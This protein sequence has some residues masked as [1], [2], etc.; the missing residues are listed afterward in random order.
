MIGA[1]R[2]LKDLTGLRAHLED[3]L[4]ARCGERPDLETSLQEDYRKAF[5]RERTAGTYETWREERLTQ[6]AVAWILGC[7]F[8]RFLEDNA[9]VDPPRLSG[10]GDRRRRALDEHNLYFRAHPTDTDRE[11]L[12]H[13][14]RAVAA[15]PVAGQLFDETHNPLWSTDPEILS[16]DAA[17]R[18]LAL[19]QRI[20]PDSGALTH[21]FTDPAWDTRFLGDLY[22]NLSESARKRYALLQTPEFVEEFI[23]DRTLDP[24]VEEFGFREVRLI[25]PA[26]G[27]GHFLLGAFQRLD[28]LWARHEPG[29]NPRER[30]SRVLEQVAGVDL[31]P[32]AAAITRFRLCV[33]ALRA[34]DVRRLDDAPA[35]ELRVAAG[36][37]LLH[38]PRSGL[39]GARQEY[40]EAVATDPL[41]HVYRTEDA[42]ALRT[43]LGRRYHV[44]VGN[45]PYITPKDN[46]EN[47]E[48]RKRFGSCYRQY[49]L[50]VPFTERFFDLAH[51]P[52][53]GA[54]EPAGFVGMIT[55]NSFMKREFGR[56]LIE[57]FIPRWDLTHVVD[58]S[59]AYIPGHGTPTVILFGQHR[60]PVERNVRAVMGIRGEPA[61][62]D[63]PSNGLVW[64]AIVA[65]V[66]RPGSQSEFVSV[67][68]VPRE[69]FQ[70]H[71]WSIG[72]G[73]AAELKESLEANSGQ[74]LRTS[75]SVVGRSTVLGEDDIWILVRASAARL[76][77]TEYMVNLVVGESLRDWEAFE[78][79]LVIYPYQSLGGPPVNAGTYLTTHYLWPY[80]T[81]LATR[82]VFGKDLADME[83]PWYEHLEHYREKLR[84][85]LSIAFAFV[86]THNHFVLDRGGNL[87]N[88][89]APVI[90]LPAKATEDD[91]LGLL[92]LLNSSTACFWMKQ[93]FHNKG[94]RGI[95]G[96]LTT[97]DWEQF[98][99]FDGTKLQTFPVPDARPLNLARELDTLARART[100]TLPAGVI[101]RS[102]PSAAFVRAARNQARRIIEQ[103]IALQE[104]LDWSCYQLFGVTEDDLCAPRGLAPG[105]RLGERAFE[106][107]LARRI[108]AGEVETKWFERHGSTA[109][110]EIPDHWPAAYRVLVQ[111]RIEAIENNANVALIEQPEYKRR[112]ND[113]AWETQQERALRGWLLDRLEAPSLWPEPRLTTTAAVAD[114]MR[115]DQEFLQVAELY[116][117]RPDF[118]VAKLVAGLVDNESVPLLSVLRYKPS[119]LRTRAAWER[120]WD[121][122]RREDAIDARVELPASDP[123]HLT[124]EEAAAL[125]AKEIGAIPVPPRYTSA[126]FRKGFWWR[127]RG[128]LD[129][130]KERFVSL[131]FCERE[132]DPSLVIG[133]AGWNVLD[134]S[135]AVAAYFNHM[136]E[137]EGWTAER[138][139]PL[140]AALLE[141]LPWVRQYHN[142]PDPD[143]DVGMG[144]YFEGFIDEEARALALTPEAVRAWA[145]PAG[146]AR[147]GD[148]RRSSDVGA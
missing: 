73:G 128:K 101:E 87:F 24:A 21:D 84:R 107:V 97:E 57:E 17:T 28:A 69:R 8:V 95:G 134:Q 54:A 93:V 142:A 112:W 114:R 62:P 70:K 104:E 141:L 96:G 30:A 33:A 88:R 46:A 110:T 98:Y 143:F 81:L 29:T 41:G 56:K 22:Q 90:K 43:I 78:L 20:D 9:L 91:H 108:A 10:P 115:E 119:G 146:R 47:Q 55:A 123:E 64:S 147:R 129:V 58:T 16:G 109:I 80:R 121:L 60:G 37:S 77:V 118:D 44:V 113:E 130:P 53:S 131:P 38:G 111:R 120:T 42:E 105:I 50:A 135:K 2:L 45:P 25:D 3:D 1:S 122:Q 106:I 125:K 140:L 27:S 72:G 68:D 63:D 49:S 6:V 133:W 48:Y 31:N 66:D 13:V 15:L 82:S 86:A 12:L 71:P 117:G 92:G 39:A 75:I 34:S 85:P 132:A 99:E 89:S 83:R 61:I 11:Y 145:P 102:A 79:P 144:D 136:R 94:I 51:A 126:D 59:G 74:E 124:P 138:L 148:R 35:F 14:F 7:V 40:L 137:Q 127:L 76:R 65:Q 23:L 100:D 52:A 4:R 36:D 26:C 18:L 5:T 139:T 19:W 116:T 103:L 32:F 67:S